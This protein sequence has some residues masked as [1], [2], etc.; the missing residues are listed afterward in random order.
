MLSTIRR[1]AAFLDRWHWVWLALAAPF[2]MFPSP[3]RSLALLV[4]PV[5]WTMAWIAG[6][7]PL[8]RTPLNR[9]LLLLNGMVLVSLYATYDVTVSLPKIGGMVLA[10]G[11][12]YAVAREARRPGGWWPSFLAFL[13]MGLGVAGLGLL[14]TPWSAKAPVLTFIT[15][16]SERH[17]T[18]LPGAKN[19]FNPNE[20]AGALLWVVP[21]IITF[22]ALWLAR[23][24]DL[25]NTW[26]R[27][28]AAAVVSLVASDGL[29][30]VMPLFVTG[31]L[32]LTQSRSAYIAFA[33]TSLALI[34]IA[35]RPRERRASLGMLGVLA[36]VGGGLL[37]QQGTAAVEA[38]LLGGD[39]SLGRVEI[40]SHA[41]R[42][43]LDFPL[44]G[45]GMN[46]FRYTMERDIAHAHNEFLQ[47]ALDL[48]L[49]GMIAFVALY[50]G[51]FWM[52]A[53]IWQATQRPEFMTWAGEVQPWPLDARSLTQALAL[54]LG[55]GLFAHLIYGLTDAV[56]LGAKPGIL[57][58][59]LLGLIS[60]LFVQTQ[61]GAEG[62]TPQEVGDWSTAS[63][64]G[65]LSPRHLSLSRKGQATGSER[66]DVFG[67]ETDRI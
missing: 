62:A 66:K 47:A 1:A 59:T 44:T 26:K 3:D 7:G 41:I 24:K 58:W 64:H 61:H 33:L 45:M 16:G 43:V 25:W 51:A 9:A 2:L 60:G 65:I 4:V 5:L 49:P 52:L 21:A 35:L 55:G 27:T 19:G 23:T 18:G 39:L 22:S 34:F 14:G 12:F 17:L 32:V 6:R 56:A 46:T 57:F 38:G 11:V 28:R 54:G 31:V 48:G 29:M 20:V 10:A 15:S 42:I 50:V 67:A 40:W 53:K 36:V 37:V 30:V 13:G 8:P 63:G